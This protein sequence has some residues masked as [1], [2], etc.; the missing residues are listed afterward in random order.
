MA[1]RKKRKNKKSRKQV[2]PMDPFLLSIFTN[3]IR[4]QCKFALQAEQ[5]ITQALASGETF[6][7]FFA[8]QAFLVAVG[9]VSMLLWPGRPLPGKPTIANRGKELRELLNVP[10]DS[11][12]RKRNFRNHSEHFDSRL[13]EWAATSKRRNLA[14]MNIMHTGAIKG[15]DPGDFLRNFDPNKFAFT[16]RGET[17]EI[18]KVRA[19]LESLL[20][21]ATQHSIPYA[22]HLPE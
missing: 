8:L 19:A 10:Q 7:V 13:E 3:E 9:H 2:I 14:D 11:P 22:Q 12:F 16:F 6:K 21:A 15:M 4:T 5:Q 18:A 20:I 1:R 17:Y